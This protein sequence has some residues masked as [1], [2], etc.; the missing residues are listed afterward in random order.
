MKK[1]L[2][3][4]AVLLV[5]VTAMGQNRYGIKSGSYK[6][7][8]DMM[9]QTITNT[10]YFDDYGAKEVTE[11]DMMGMQM[12]QISKDGVIYIVNKGDK[13]VQEMPG[14][15]QINYLNLTDEII[16]KYKVKEIGNETVS[17]KECTIYTAEIN[18][19]GQTAK[20][21]VSVWNGF[22]M[23]SSIDM[24]GFA[25]NQKIV[26]INEGPVDAAKFEVPKF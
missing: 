16:A 10:T 19:M 12:T 20:A 8:M 6:T 15:D 23:K 18:Q 1:I 5:A 14:R 7:E 3:I 4:C 9:G 21:T 25:M 22:A 17:G 11:M 2:S 13:S 24:G 26:E